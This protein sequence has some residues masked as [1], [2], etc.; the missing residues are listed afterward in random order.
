MK[1]AIAG[2]ADSNLN[3]GVTSECLAL[4]TICLK[5]V[6]EAQIGDYVPVHVGFAPAQTEEGGS[7][8]R[9]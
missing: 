2:N 8:A 9:F 7:K 5:Y 1:I 4:V 3:F 6:P